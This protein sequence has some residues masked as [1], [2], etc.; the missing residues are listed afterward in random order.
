MKNLEGE[1][2]YGAQNETVVRLGTLS[3][4]STDLLTHRWLSF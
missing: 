1:I 3:Y 2:F 4:L